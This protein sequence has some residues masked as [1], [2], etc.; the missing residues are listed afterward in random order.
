MSEAS[1]ADQPFHTV[2]SP[3]Q[4]LRAAREAKG[5]HV[6]AL[7]ASI[8]VPARKIELLEADQ[9]E[10]LPDMAFARALA[11]TVCRSLGIDSGSIVSG[12][13]QAQT[14]SIEQ[15]AQGLNT[16]FRERL[17]GSGHRWAWIGHPLTWLAVLVLLAAGLLHQLPAYWPD[18]A[19]RMQRSEQPQEAPM[20]P[21][22][23]VSPATEA[24]EAAEQVAAPTVEPSR[25]SMPDVADSDPLAELLV[26]LEAK[27][28]SRQ[29]L[30]VRV[31]APSWIKVQDAT[32]KIVFNR[33]LQPGPEPVAI[34]GVEPLKLRIGNAVVTEV[35]YRGRLLDLTTFTRGNVA[36]LDLK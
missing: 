8:R 33:V 14:H 28:A 17:A 2:L 24:T 7:A 30:E 15:V 13:P 3:G 10:A 16:P 29:P 5:L 25:P 27:S 32:G 23:N 34:G 35:K 26:S 36:R 21:P 1:P 31:K 9:W 11:L 4:L 18:L 20:E 19:D 12:L 22:S 6:A